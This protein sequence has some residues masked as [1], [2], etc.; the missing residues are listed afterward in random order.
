M[1]PGSR[2]R[3]GA[4]RATRTVCNAETQRSRRGA[5]GR[6][7]TNLHGTRRREP[8]IRDDERTVVVLAPTVLKSLA[9]RARIRAA[10]V[11]AIGMR[12]TKRYRGEGESAAI[13]CGL[14]GS[15]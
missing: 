5:E 15:L 10:P 9:A 4:L 7:S 1:V 11:R 13:I 8:R 6:I 3:I 12:A 2:I 14:A